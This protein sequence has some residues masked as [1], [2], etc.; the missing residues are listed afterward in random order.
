M[1]KNNDKTVKFVTIIEKNI[2]TVTIKRSD[3]VT[4]SLTYKKK[5]IMVMAL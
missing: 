5:S 2:I 1:I 4:S 3:I